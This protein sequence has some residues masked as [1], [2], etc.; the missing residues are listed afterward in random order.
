LFV[1]DREINVE[2]ARAVGIHAIRFQ[3]VG[4]FNDE[5]AALGFSVLPVDTESSSAVPSI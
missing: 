1:D 5:L 3:T 2:G 4:Q